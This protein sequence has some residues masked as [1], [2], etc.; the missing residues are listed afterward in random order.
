MR[1]A[2][3]AIVFVLSC[4]DAAPKSS[5]PDAAAAT[6]SSARADASAPVVDE[7]GAELVVRFECRRCHEDGREELA[8]ASPREDKH[9]YRCHRAIEKGDIQA[10]NEATTAVW[11]KRVV[12]LCDVPS[13]V[14]S[15]K[16]LRRDWI[17]RFLLAPFDVRPRLEPTMPRLALTE[18]Q[19]N[20]IAAYYAQ[21]EPSES[22]HAIEGADATRGRALLDAKGCGACHAFTG[23]RALVGTSKARAS[24][25]GLTPAVRLAPDLRFTRDRF[26]PR[27]LVAWLVSPKAMKPDTPMPETGLHEDEARDIA[28]YLLTTP[29]VEPVRARMPDRL[30]LLTR[31]VSYAEVSARVFR[32]TCWHCHSDPDYAIGDGGPGNSGGF[33]FSPRGLNLAEYEGIASGELDEHG[34]RRSVFSKAG[35]GEPRIVGVLLSRQREE[36]GIAPIEG[37]LQGMPLGLPALA[38]QDVQLVE[39]WVAQG[40]P[41]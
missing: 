25:D 9:C 31:S 19:A 28:A 29:L 15:E 33:G 34:E 39:S 10:R 18:K 6:A 22:A 5:A 2:A 4:R 3:L 41:R 27:A 20:A 11:K 13:L 23:A 24:D 26:Q 40:R 1:R 16:R 21:D 14:A 8:A 36:N 7:S 17:A 38:P 32:R 37:S 35:D 30:P 12:R